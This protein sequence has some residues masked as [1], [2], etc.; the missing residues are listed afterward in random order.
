MAKPT[1]AAAACSVLLAC[2]A[3]QVA[4]CADG[5]APLG[6][7]LLDGKFS[8]DARYRVESVEQDNNLKSALAST[9]RLRAGFETNPELP[10]GAVLEAEDIRTIGAEKFNSTTNGRTNYSVVP[11]PDATEI[12]QAYLSARGSGWRVRAGRQAFVLDNG[13][14]FGDLAF[15]QNQQ[16]FDAATAQV[17][18]PGGSRFIYG[19]LWRAR[20]ILG[21]DHPLGDVDLNTHVLNYSYGWLNGNRL[22]TYGYLTEIEE[23]AMQS[24]STQTWG[25]S[26]D[27]SMDMKAQ[28]LLYRAEYAVQSDYANNPGTADAWYANAEVG[29][30]FPNQWVANAG[31]EILSGDGQ[32]G[33]QTPFGT[34][35]KFNGFASVFAER[36]PNDGLEDRYLGAYVPVAGMRFTLT[37][38]DLRAENAGHHYGTELDAELSWRIT[39][40]WLAAARVADYRAKEFA[41]DTRK[42]LFWVEARF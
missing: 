34:L 40:H 8:F 33:F 39:P 26:F 9:L 38:H 22:T 20:R 24:L 21:E 17:T 35:I 6:S 5:K 27:G 19:Y 23:R 29:V 18:T 15:R 2:A 12:N 7:A 36:T 31:V 14:F 1:S 13:R 42:A 41:V 16:T 3:P 32:Y 10:F 25:A 11:E 28:R 30:R 37:W 4:N